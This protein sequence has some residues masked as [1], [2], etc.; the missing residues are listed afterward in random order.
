MRSQRG[1]GEDRDARDASTRASR[2]VVAN[3]LANARDLLAER[4]D[5]LEARARGGDATAWATYLV[6]LQ[7]LTAVLER[8]DVQELGAPLTT[9]AMAE[10]LGLKPK[11]LL[12]HKARGSIR[13]AVQAGKLIRW[14][15]DERLG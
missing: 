14:R 9:R 13:P 15:G 12:R 1:Q 3:Q 10:R 5:A 7:T 4:L 11:A 6:T 2:Q 8:L